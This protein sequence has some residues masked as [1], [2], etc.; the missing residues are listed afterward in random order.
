MRENLKVV[1]PEFFNFKLGRTAIPHG[2]CVAYMRPL[3]ELIPWPWF[4]PV[5]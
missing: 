4:C 5:S 1:G 3:L 2:K